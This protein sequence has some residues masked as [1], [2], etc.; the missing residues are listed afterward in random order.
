MLSSFIS[1]RVDFEALLAVVL[2][3][4][5]IFKGSR[6]ERL[7]AATFAGMWLIDKLF[8]A[9]ARAA[10]QGAFVHTGHLLVDVLALTAF[11]GIALHANRV[12]PLWIAGFQLISLI[13]HIVRLLNPSIGHM[14]LAL[15]MI[16]P[17]YLEILAFAIGIWHHLRRSPR[18]IPEPF[19]K[20]F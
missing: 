13:A 7:I 20:D 4:L 10:N 9:L 8:H 5:A 3:V 2:C 17:S 16:V 11:V 14:A 19:W 18:S 12:Y 15:L 6:P 1:A